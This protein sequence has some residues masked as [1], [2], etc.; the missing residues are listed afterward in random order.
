MLGTLSVTVGWISIDREGDTDTGILKPAP[1]V[2]LE[3][4]NSL[5]KR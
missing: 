3:I 1:G 4:F 5:T 2:Y